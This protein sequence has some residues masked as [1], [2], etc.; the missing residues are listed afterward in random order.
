MKVYLEVGRRKVFACAPEWPGWCRSGKTE[1]QALEALG[2]YAERYAVVAA[3]AG[4]RFPKT[5][6]T[7]FDVTERLPGD[8]TTDFGAPSSIAADDRR[9][10]TRAQAQRLVRFVE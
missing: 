6:G 5:A 10:T 3:A 2:T 1:E 9:P 8:A 4:V 7:S